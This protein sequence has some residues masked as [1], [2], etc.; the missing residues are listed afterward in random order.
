[1]I[2]RVYKQRDFEATLQPYTTAGDPAIGI[3]RAYQTNETRRPWISPSG[4]SNPEVDR[5]LAKAASTPDLAERGKYYK[6]VAP[7][8]VHDVASVLLLE[9]GEVDFANKKFKGLWVSGM[10]YDKWDEVW[11]TGGRDAP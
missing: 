4:Y 7:I 11:F 5:L 1:M 3:H 10:P 9:R 2:G 8:L 6:Q